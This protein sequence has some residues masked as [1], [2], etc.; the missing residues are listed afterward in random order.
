MDPS[1]TLTALLQLMVTLIHD[2]SPET[3]GASGAGCAV[4]SEAKLAAQS[5]WAVPVGNVSRVFLLYDL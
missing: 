1:G 4:N 5:R 2:V 3:G